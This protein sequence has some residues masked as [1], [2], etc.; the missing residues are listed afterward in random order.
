MSNLE[1][2]R[3]FICCLTNN[4]NTLNYAVILEF[5]FRNLFKSL[6]C[7]EIQNT[8]NGFHYVL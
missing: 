1:L 2:R 3:Q 4:L 5:V 8:A 6:V 7:H